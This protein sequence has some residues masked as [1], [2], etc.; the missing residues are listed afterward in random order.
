MNGISAD[1]TVKYYYHLV[2]SDKLLGNSPDAVGGF[3]VRELLPE[4]KSGLMSRRP[5]FYHTIILLLSA[6]IDEKSRDWIT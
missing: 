4:C 3:I 6:M 2:F 5:S 1:L